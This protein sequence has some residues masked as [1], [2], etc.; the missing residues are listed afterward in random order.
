M[1]DT[2]FNIANLLALA[3]W[4]I[5]I[6][7]PRKPFAMALVLYCGVGLLCLTYV[8]LLV[9][10]VSGVFDPVREAGAGA[11][12]FGDFSLSGIADLF[13]SE[14]GVTTGWVH[15]LA[16][17]LFIG[18]WIARDADAKGFSRWVQAPI[19]LA[20]FMAGPLGLFVWLLMRERRARAAGR[21][22]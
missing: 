21:W 7:L 11:A 2:V 13:R 10:L 4:A 9:G 12:N 14:G 18:V 15:Y 19:L 16:F 22:S 8:V 5:L 3:M 1:W 17:D 6:L 20:T